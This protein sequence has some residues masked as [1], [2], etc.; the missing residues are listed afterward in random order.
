MSHSRYRW[1]IRFPKGDTALTLFLRQFDTLCPA[2]QFQSNY[3][4]RFVTT[5][6]FSVYPHAHNPSKHTRTVNPPHHVSSPQVPPPVAMN[7]QSPSHITP[8]HLALSMNRCQPRVYKVREFF[9]LLRTHQAPHCIPV[10][11]FRTTK[12]FQS[13]AYFPHHGA[14]PHWWTRISKISTQSDRGHQQTSE[15]IPAG[16]M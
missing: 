9:Q 4:S 14:R 13:L 8:I 3:A 12:I 5:P 15:E 7:R 2:P 16:G 11:S 1:S 6:M 10:V